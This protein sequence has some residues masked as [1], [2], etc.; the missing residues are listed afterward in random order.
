[1][2]RNSMRCDAVWWERQSTL[3]LV[4][5][6]LMEMGMDVDTDMGMDTDMDM[7]TEHGTLMG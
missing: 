2:Q 5:D 3:Y 1:M 4:H 6:G 7:D